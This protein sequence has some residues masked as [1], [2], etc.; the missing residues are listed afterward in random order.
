M[1]TWQSDLYALGVAAM[2][3]AHAE[4]CR[5]VDAASRA[6]D[7]DFPYLLH[8]LIEHTRGHF[9]HEERLMRECGFPALAEHASEHRRVL[10]ELLHMAN[11]VEEGRLRFARLYVSQGLP[12]WFRNHLATMDAALA[13][14]LKREATRAP[15]D[16]TLPVS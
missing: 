10:G 8:A 3:A 5:L 11:A 13:A 16:D 7:E 4:F 9:D 12:A 1:L 2:D 15:A 14:S 6:S